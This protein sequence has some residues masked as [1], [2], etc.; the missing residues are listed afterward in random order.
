MKILRAL[1]LALCLA[2]PLLAVGCGNAVAPIVIEAGRMDAKTL[3]GNSPAH[4]FAV[5]LL[6]GALSKNPDATSFTVNFEAGYPS[7][8]VF[9]R[10]L[11]YDRSAQTL[12]VKGDKG[13][14]TSYSGVT[15]TIIASLASKKQEIDS[16]VDY[17]A[18][19]IP[20][21]LENPS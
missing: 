12:S 16:A 21:A 3:S 8:A 14:G 19:R 5:F 7:G 17:G 2:S 20:Q 11:V 1:K 9:K 4:A 13:V 15:D 10:S 6:S 18:T